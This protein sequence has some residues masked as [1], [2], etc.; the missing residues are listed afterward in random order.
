MNR[1]R[2][3]SVGAGAIGIT[4]AT[5]LVTDPTPVSGQQAGELTI[6]EMSDEISGIYLEGMRN[7]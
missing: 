6:T 7:R 4:L 5:S 3:Q 2:W 1:T